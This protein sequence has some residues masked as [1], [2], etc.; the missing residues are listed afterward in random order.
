MRDT[1]E[2]VLSETH[3]GGSVPASFVSRVVCGVCDSR[4]SLRRV[5][6][7]GEEEERA[8]LAAEAILGYKAAALASCSSSHPQ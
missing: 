7:G 5:F 4:R 8:L 1:R 3:G 6:F 2:G